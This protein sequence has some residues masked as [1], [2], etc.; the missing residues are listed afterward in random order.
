M[1]HQFSSAVPPRASI[2]EE[3]GGYDSYFTEPWFSFHHNKALN[4][5]RLLHI[6][7]MLH[8]MASTNLTALFL[9]G[10]PL[11]TTSA[12]FLELAFLASFYFPVPPYH[13]LL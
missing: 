13:D 3:Y 11:K 1:L 4:S 10:P 9:S 7:V 5:S 6:P 12:L 8:K 2:F